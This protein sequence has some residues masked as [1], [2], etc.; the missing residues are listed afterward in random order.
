[1]ISASTILLLVVAAIVLW[2]LFSEIPLPATVR[3][4]F[5]IIIGV[6]LLLWLLSLMGFVAL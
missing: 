3:N 6:A 4:I 2:L 5:A 1:M